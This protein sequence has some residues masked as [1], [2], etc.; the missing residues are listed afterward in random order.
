MRPKFGAGATLAENAAVARALKA[1]FPILSREGLVYLDTAASAQ[2][3]LAVLEA[4]AEFYRHSYANVHRGIH[5]LGEEAT[6]AYEDARARMKKLIGAERLTELIFTRGTTES[7]NLVARSLGDTFQA[8]DEIILSEMEHHANLVPWHMLAERKGVVLRFVPITDDGE[9]DMAAYEGL[10]GKKT[11]LVALS[12]ASNVLGTVN[13]ARRIVESAHAAGSLVLLDAAQAV[14]RSL[15]HAAELGADFLAF[16]GHKMYGPTGIGVLYGR[17]SVLEAMPPFMGGGEM[18]SE[19]RL[20][21]FKPNE[22]PYKF[23]AGTP[24]IAQAVGLSAAATWLDSVDPEALGEY[25]S[26]LGGRL[27]AALDKIPKVRVIG[28]AKNRAGIVAFNLEGVHAH[29]LSAWLDRSGIAV[30]AGQH[31]AQPLARRMGVIST[32]RASLGAYN[33]P[34]DVDFLAKLVARATEEL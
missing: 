19:V 9:L 5:T 27:I 18:I 33:L 15:L 24:P 22:L 7:I 11:R 25:E 32:A 12:M 13:P 4:E 6:R 29:D 30:R 8:G 28:R 3:P 17:E 31:C 10:L 2:K 16:S 23:E 34:E 21:G 14:P 20:D 1:E 26:A